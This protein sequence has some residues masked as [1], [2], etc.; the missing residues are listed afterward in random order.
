MKCKLW[1]RSR[2]GRVSTRWL[3]QP[4][5]QTFHLAVVHGSYVVV[6][7]Q[8]VVVGAV[9]GPVVDGLIVDDAAVH[10]LIVV[11][12]EV[13]G[14]MVVGLFTEGGPMK[15]LSNAT[16]SSTCLLQKA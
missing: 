2:I 5:E 1:N 8:A 13:G 9:G 3:Y 15:M 4:N 14:L 11:D 10:G 6:D 16:A 7:G 12:E